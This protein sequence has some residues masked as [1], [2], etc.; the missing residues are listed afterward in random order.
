MAIPVNTLLPP[1]APNLPIGPT[2]YDRR[3][4]DQ[5]NNAL[6]IYF[7]QLDNTFQTLLSNDP[8]GS[9][10]RFPFG[11]FKTLPPRPLPPTPPK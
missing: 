4:Q 9:Y 6:R 7:N 2:A 3:Y 1:K 10:I 11:S 8:G 5:F